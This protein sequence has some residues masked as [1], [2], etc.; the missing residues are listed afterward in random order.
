[1]RWKAN[2]GIDDREPKTEK[3]KQKREAFTTEEADRAEKGKSGRSC[4]RPYIYRME[5]VKMHS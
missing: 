3:A 1:M 4:E 5:Q 2:P